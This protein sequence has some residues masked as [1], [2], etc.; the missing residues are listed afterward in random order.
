MYLLTFDG[1]WLVLVVFHYCKSS[2]YIMILDCVV[3]ECGLWYLTGDYLWS[4]VTSLLPDS[5]WRFYSH[6]LWECLLT[7]TLPSPVSLPSTSITP[8]PLIP[9]PSIQWYASASTHLPPISTLS[10]LTPIMY[11][12]VVPMLLQI[13][14]WPS[15]IRY[16]V[17]WLLHWDSTNDDLTLL[18]YLLII[19]R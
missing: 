2:H 8:F 7:S 13:I 10:H 4:Y 12:G 9:P 16:W 15:T 19:Y 17:Y 3:C 14:H 6:S 5:T 1:F 11:N 18:T